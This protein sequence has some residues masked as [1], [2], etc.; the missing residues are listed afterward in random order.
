LQIV[1]GSYY[2]TKEYV[3]QILG[4]KNTAN[5]PPADAEITFIITT[6]AGPFLLSENIVAL[7]PLKNNQH[8]HN[9]K[10]PVTIKAGL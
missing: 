9:N 1:P 4:L 6:L 7:P 2:D 10:V 8:T 3:P 5:K